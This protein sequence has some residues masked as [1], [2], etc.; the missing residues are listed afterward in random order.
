VEVERSSLDAAAIDLGGIAGQ[1]ELLATQ[2]VLCGGT[3]Q[4]Y[5][6]EEEEA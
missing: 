5:V 4:R 6:A 2:L 1:L 3:E